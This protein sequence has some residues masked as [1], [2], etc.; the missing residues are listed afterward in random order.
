MKHP[1]MVW[2]AVIWMGVSSAQAADP[3]SA[4]TQPTAAQ[5]ATQAA[6][7]PAAT[8][9]VEDDTPLPK[10]YEVFV[11]ELEM[12]SR[13]VAQLRRTIRQSAEKLDA[14]D[15]ENGAAV[16]GMQRELVE[17][18]RAGD[19]ESVTEIQDRLAK[20]QKGRRDILDGHEKA[21]VSILSPRQKQQYAALLVAADAVDAYSDLKLNDRQID[22]IKTLAAKVR[23]RIEKAG[24]DK[25][26]VDAAYE[27]FYKDIESRVLTAEQLQQLKGKK[28]K[29]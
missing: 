4:D 11:R 12:S 10:A 17:A 15:K 16:A 7:Q 14:W 19:R 18:H 25:P 20:L 2:A 3:A 21:F 29:S 9:P 6:T 24:D 26:A 28:E 5:P 22:V 1:W 27:Q 8:R 13:Q 23:E